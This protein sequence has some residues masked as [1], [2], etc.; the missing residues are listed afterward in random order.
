[1]DEASTTR[2]L[3]AGRLEGMEM[4]VVEAGDPKEVAQALASGAFD[5]VVSELS[6]PGLSRE[7]LFRRYKTLRA[8]LLLYTEKVPEGDVR[9]WGIAQVKAVFHKSQRADLLKKVAELVEGPTRETTAGARQILLIEDSPTIRNMMR[10][11]LE[12]NFP[13][14]AIR[15]ASEGREAMAEMSNKKVDLILTD[16]QMPGMDGEAFLRMLRGNPV[17]KHKPVVVFSAS[18]TAALRNEVAGC[19]NIRLLPKPSSEAEITSVVKELIGSEERSCV[20]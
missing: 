9:D 18:I 11:L 10:R 8:P 7:E 12:R 14:C 3:L 20:P 6:L 5:L 4:R 17:L 15:E 2:K 16:L 1:V 13:G 19:G